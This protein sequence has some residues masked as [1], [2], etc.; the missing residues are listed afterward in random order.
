MAVDFAM[1]LSHLTD[2]S[3]I[4]N[5]VLPAGYRIALV[6]E[7]GSKKYFE[8]TIFLKGATIFQPLFFPY[9]A[10][11]HSGRLFIKVLL[12]VA[13]HGIPMINMRLACL[14]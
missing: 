7:F 12:R 10:S 6:S 2:Y 3:P 13:F 1:A 5:D 9:I 14:L 11:C 8:T 4:G